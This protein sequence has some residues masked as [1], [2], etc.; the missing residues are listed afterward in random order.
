MRQHPENGH[1]R[2]SQ[3]QQPGDIRNKDARRVFTL[4]A[5]IFRE[6][7]HECLGKR[8]FSKNTTQQVRQFERDEKGVRGHP[9]TKYPCHNGVARKTQHA[10][11]HGHRA[12]GRQRF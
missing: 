9:C 6:Y 5:F 3:R 2:Q 1:H 4:L 8:P 11:K 10:G 7:R 12:D